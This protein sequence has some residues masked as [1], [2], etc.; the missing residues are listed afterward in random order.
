MT[1]EKVFTVVT[2][3]LQIALILFC[4]IRGFGYA[5]REK[6]NLYLIFYALAMAA[7]LCS[8]L[9]WFAHTELREGLRV[10]FA[11]DDIADFGLYL[12]LGS[13]L[14]AAVE[15]RECPA[16]VTAA[17]GLFA[18]AN[19]ALWIGWSGEWLRSVFGGLAYGYF[20][21]IVARTLA[22]TGALSRAERFALPLLCLLLIAVQGA[23]ILCP[24]LPRGTL[25]LIAYVLLFAVLAWLP[26][27]AALSLRKP[28]ADRAMAL[29]FA[30][31]CWITVT[32]YMA[33]GVWYTVAANLTDLG[34]L[35]LFLAVGKKV[36]AA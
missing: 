9:Y 20:L 8:D 32:M 19:A 15:R 28:D 1:G 5:R 3:L 13:A 29:C 30:A 11:A 22:A 12:L 26:L 18:A 33:D 23:T 4:L 25:D 21:I 31:F 35:L 7:F 14:G 10:P 2:E 27:R 17:A 6:N 36:R 16:W 34:L 24:A